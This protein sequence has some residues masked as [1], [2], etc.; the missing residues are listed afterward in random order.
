MKRLA[1]GDLQFDGRHVYGID[2]VAHRHVNRV[3]MVS[4]LFN[5]F[6]GLGIHFNKIVDYNNSKI[7]IILIKI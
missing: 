7:W 6:L 3:F 4:M 1:F 2:E 5:V